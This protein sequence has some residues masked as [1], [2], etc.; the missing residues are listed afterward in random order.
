[1]ALLLYTR[2][3][4][5]SFLLG[6]QVGSDPVFVPFLTA[7]GHRLVAL[8]RIS[9]QQQ[10]Y[11]QHQHHTAAAATHPDPSTAPHDVD[12]HSQPSSG[13]S[14]SSSAPVPQRRPQW[15]AGAVVPRHLAATVH[16]FAQLR[17][18]LGELMEAVAADVEARAQRWV[19]RGTPLLLWESGM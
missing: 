18:D 2:R 6:P 19:T 4:F 1:M 7:L 17:F 15:G 10:Q 3:T 8:L 16:A 11:H 9:Q 12:A 13:S 5:L 14:A